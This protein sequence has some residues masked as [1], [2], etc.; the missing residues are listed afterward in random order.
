MGDVFTVLTMS[1]DG[2]IAGPNDGPGRPL[3]EEGERLF[4][5][6]GSGDT[7]FVMPSGAMTVKCR[8]SQC[9]SPAGAGRNVRSVGNGTEDI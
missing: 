9:R 3:G 4:T 2:F 6:Y 5:W 1:L 8:G 7:D